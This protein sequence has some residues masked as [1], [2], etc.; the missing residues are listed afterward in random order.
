MI[1]QVR[2]SHYKVPIMPTVDIT[3]VN[4]GETSNSNGISVAGVT[5]LNLKGIDVTIP[6]D[7]FVLLTGRSLSGK[8]ALGY[9]TLYQESLRRMM[10]TRAPIKKKGERSIVQPQFREIKGLIPAIHLNDNV[11]EQNQDELVLDFFLL[12]N[13]FAVSF[14]Q[15]GLPV[16]KRCKQEMSHASPH[17]VARQVV[18][19]FD[20]QL[21]SDVSPRPD[22]AQY[23]VLIGGEFSSNTNPG[24]T[25]QALIEEYRERGFRRFMRK[26]QFYTFVTPEQDIAE[27]DVAPLPKS[28]KSQWELGVVFQAFSA[29]AI[30]EVLLVQALQEVFEEGCKTA[31]ISCYPKT[32]FQ[33]NQ[34]LQ[35]IPADILQWSVVDGYA[36]KQCKETFPALTP[37]MFAR[38]NRDGTKLAQDILQVHVQGKPVFELL[39]DTLEGVLTRFQSGLYVGKD[40]KKI[41]A[42]LGLSQVRVSQCLHEL[43]LAERT[44]LALAR[45][46]FLGL[47]DTLLIFEDP[48]PGF[49]PK[50]IAELGKGLKALVGLGNTVLVMSR[51]A[52][53]VSLADHVIELG[54]SAQPGVMSAP[55]TGNDSRGGG[56]LRYSGVVADWKRLDEDGESR[57]EAAHSKGSGDEKAAMYTVP[58]VPFLGGIIERVSFPLQ[59]LVAVTGSANSGLSALMRQIVADRRVL[60]VRKVIALNADSPQQTLAKA[61]GVSTLIRT[62]FAGL[63][64]ARRAGLSEK[65]FQ[66]DEPGGR[67]EECVGRGF[68]EF[69]FADLGRVR[70]VCSA[71]LG[72]CFSYRTLKVKYQELS[73]GDLYQ[74]PLRKL[75]GL[76][77]GHSDLATSLLLAIDFGL[78]N[79]RLGQRLQDQSSAERQRIM[80]LRFG[81][82]SKKRRT[83]SL[84]VLEDPLGGL[85]R[86]Y[87]PLALKMLRSV[88]KISQASIVFSAFDYSVIKSSDWIVELDESKGVVFSDFA[89]SYPQPPSHFS[90]ENYL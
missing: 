69:D 73:I 90:V 58:N 2:D 44:K 33:T 29:D 53:L 22:A 60:G 85:S 28:K 12:R 43:T 31:F 52:A 14:S 36:C 87:L 15:Q 68:V 66:L 81:L 17:V 35:T 41:L 65:D 76:V 78:E 26:N 39:G 63:P 61:L 3:N 48:S 16:C 46:L 50:D 11:E 55:E 32:F 64:E 42:V 24:R 56:F 62:V 67:C 89:L 5:T 4:T 10:G 23:R 13:L 25:E 77:S 83:G 71:C 21:T 79:C 70:E 75:L 72:Q 49:H 40:L 6:C 19:T 54:L 20:R 74:L 80:L 84:Y 86:E 51:S 82:L 30:D 59:S 27:Q 7:R 8:S 57:V 47:V 1:D 88:V 45:F 9:W 18:Q 37:Q 34:T 38:G